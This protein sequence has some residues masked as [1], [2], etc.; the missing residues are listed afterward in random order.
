MK[1]Q[2]DLLSRYAGFD[3]F[4]RDSVFRAVVLNP[5]HSPAEYRRLLGGGLRKRTQRRAM[6]GV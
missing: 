6:A 2:D 3:E 5:N 1:R 4:F